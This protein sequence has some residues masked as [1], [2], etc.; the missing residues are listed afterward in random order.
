MTASEFKSTLKQIQNNLRGLTI[1][2][3]QPNSVTPFTSLREFGHSV[4]KTEATCNTY[5]INQVWTTDGVKMVTSIKELIDLFKSTK[6]EAVAFSAS[7]Q[8]ETLAEA[9]R[10]GGALD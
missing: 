1:Q 6:I 8:A 4:L 2:F 3:R 7:Y 10:M 5:S 9:I